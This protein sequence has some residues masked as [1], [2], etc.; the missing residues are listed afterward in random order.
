[1]IGVAANVTQWTTPGSRHKKRQ[2]WY[3]ALCTSILPNFSESEHEK[4]RIM[5]YIQKCK[6]KN[7]KTGLSSTGLQPRLSGPHRA[8]RVMFGLIFLLISASVLALSIWNYQLHTSCLLAHLRQLFW[9]NHLDIA[10]CTTTV[11]G[12]LYGVGR[13]ALNRNAKEDMCIQNKNIG[14]VFGTFLAPV[15]PYPWNCQMQNFT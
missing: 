4:E 8:Y 7:N 1:M 2:T 9:H 6:K 11:G 5:H 12:H 13:I 14:F 3:F 10:R 15:W